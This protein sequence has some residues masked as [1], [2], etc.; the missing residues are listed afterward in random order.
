MG[1]KRFRLTRKQAIAYDFL[2]DGVTTEIK[3][4]VL[5]KSWKHVKCDRGGD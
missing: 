1:E 2:T 5:N 4:V 3:D